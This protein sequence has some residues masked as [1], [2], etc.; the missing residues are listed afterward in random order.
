MIKTTDINKIRTWGRVPVNEL[1]AYLK[2]EGFE[3]VKQF[4][5]DEHK[6]FVS[7]DGEYMVNLVKN[8][9][10]VYSTKNQKKPLHY[11][12]VVSTEKV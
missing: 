8:L 2:G 6:I 3:Y 12:S 11:F 4:S 5:T 1:M 10:K 9:G 7:Q